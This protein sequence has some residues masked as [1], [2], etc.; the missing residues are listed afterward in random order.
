MIVACGWSPEAAGPQA[1]RLTD[2]ASTLTLADATSGE[3]LAGIRALALGPR[4]A[5][6]NPPMDCRRHES[7]T[8]LWLELA[9]DG[10]ARRFHLRHERRLFLDLATDELRGEDRLTPLGDSAAAGQRR[11]IPFLTRFHLHPQVRASLAR[12]GKSVLL[13]AEGDETGWWLRT[14]SRE[15]AIET[16]VYF[17]DGLPRRSQQV[18]LRG[19]ARLDAG[20]KVRWKLAAAEAWPPPH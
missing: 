2:A 8:G 4:L 5:G 11:F 3:P 9:H 17:Q 6:A 20:A 7:E 15:V 14:D 1:L 12:D 19:Q 16:S 10:W 13:R 18:V